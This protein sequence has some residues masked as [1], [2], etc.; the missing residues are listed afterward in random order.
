ML[1]RSEGFVPTL[2]I[3]YAGGE[4]TF[5]TAEPRAT[6]EEA[7][8]AAGTLDSDWHQREADEVAAEMAS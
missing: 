1:F 5:E 3:S 7:K 8:T 2:A 4:P 6:L